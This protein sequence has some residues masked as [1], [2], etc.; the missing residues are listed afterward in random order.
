GSAALAT[1]ATG[2]AAATT[3]AFPDLTMMLR[4]SGLEEPVGKPRIRRPEHWLDQRLRVPADPRAAPGPWRRRRELPRHVAWVPVANG[5][6]ANERA[7]V[8]D[9]RLCRRLGGKK[10]SQAGVC[11]R[12]CDVPGEVAA[13]N[14]TDDHGAAEH[15]FEPP[16]A[17]RP[18]VAHPRG[19]EC[20]EPRW[21]GR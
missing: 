19:C 8:H 9:A 10:G 21:M 5:E 11:S 20:A 15:V 1:F 17:A 12:A 3:R 7:R 18:F 16:P 4:A 13:G 2:S 14:G 6:A